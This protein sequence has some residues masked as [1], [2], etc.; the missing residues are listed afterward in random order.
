MEY[1]LYEIIA[2]NFEPEYSDIERLEMERDNVY[3]ELE[4]ALVPISKEDFCSCYNCVVMPLPEENVC[5]KESNLTIGSLNLKT[6]IVV[7]Y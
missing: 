4:I 2:Y 7:S 5:C 6:R 3:Q 1:E